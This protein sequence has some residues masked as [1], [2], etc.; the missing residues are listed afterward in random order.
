LY[1]YVVALAVGIS[2][3]L[4]RNLERS[5]WG[6]AL[7]AVRDSEIAAESIGL[8]PYWVRTVAFTLSAACAGAG[9]CL[10]AH[11]AGFVSPD[12]FTMQT[13]ILFLLIVLFGGL[14]RVTGPLV[15]S[16]VLIVLP[17][18]LHRFSDYRLVMYGVL[19]LGSIY[20]LPQG[21]VGALAPRALAW[22]RS[23]T[24]YDRFAEG[25]PSVPPQT[26]LF[27]RSAT[28]VPGSVRGGTSQATLIAKNLEMRFGGLLALADADVTLAPRTVHGLIGPNGAGKT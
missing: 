10:Y 15:G 27:A 2:L 23:R 11:L 17:E 24:P 7:V 19:L 28:E 9:G 22:R 20:F 21:V 26:P 16:M 6:R 12:S 5:P 14:G 25:G 4:A 13:S 8:N 1:Y 3:L 18:L